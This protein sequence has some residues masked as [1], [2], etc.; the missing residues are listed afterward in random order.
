M[1]TTRDGYTVRLP[2]FR[3]RRLSRR[4][5]QRPRSGRA[6]RVIG[7]ALRII[8]GRAQRGGGASDRSHPVFISNL[9]GTPIR[10]H[11]RVVAPK[12]VEVLYVRRVLRQ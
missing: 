8:V 6:L 12:R 4:L 3:L 10:I 1:W 9:G 7:R 2:R 11:T 5:R